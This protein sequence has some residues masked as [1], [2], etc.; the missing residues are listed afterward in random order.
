VVTLFRPNPKPTLESLAP[1]SATTGPGAL[2]LIVNGADFVPG[3]KVRW[4]NA[5][6]LATTFVN[7]SQLKATVTAGLLPTAGLG[8]VRV[9][10]PT[11]GGGASNSLNF[12]ITQPNQN[13]VPSIDELNPAGA[14]AGGPGFT[15]TIKGANFINGSQVRWNGANRQTTFVSA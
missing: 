12:T 5:V 3:A 15:L 6:D 7:S 10:N 11:P 1:A 14:Q 8:P 4:N 9:V 2:T 13:P